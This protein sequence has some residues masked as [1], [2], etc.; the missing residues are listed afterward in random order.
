MDPFKFFLAPV[1]MQVDPQLPTDIILHTRVFLIMQPIQC[2]THYCVH[3]SAGDIW[4]EKL[5]VLEQFTDLRPSAFSIRQP[6]CSI[7]NER[8]DGDI[9]RPVGAQQ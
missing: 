6:S 2:A 4:S 9:G 3:L 8:Q 7:P 5:R 1:T